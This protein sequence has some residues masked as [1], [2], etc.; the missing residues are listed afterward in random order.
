MAAGETYPTISEQVDFC[1]CGKRVEKGD[2]ILVWSSDWKIE[3]RILKCPNCH[4]EKYK[5][6]S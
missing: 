5:R 6:H 1:A 2:E 3:K 4:P